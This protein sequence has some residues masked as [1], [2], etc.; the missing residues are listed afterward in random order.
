MTVRPFSPKLITSD[1]AITPKNEMLEQ[2]VFDDV[3][4]SA[5]GNIKIKSTMDN[6]QKIIDGYGITLSKNVI[7]KRL[8]LDVPW[9]DS[10]DLNTAQCAIVS[11]CNLNLY[12]KG[13]VGMFTQAL[14]DNNQYN[15]VLEWI[16]SVEWD[17]VDRFTELLSHVSVKAGFEAVRDIYFKRWCFSAVGML[18]NDGRLSNE[19]VL[20][21][22]GEQGLGKSAWVRKLI[23]PMY[24]YFQDGYTLEPNN[25]D[26]V[27]TAVSNWILELGE[28]D[29]TF[30]KSEIAA[31]KAFIT[32][33]KDTYRA[34]YDRF[35]VSHPRTTVL[36][37]SVNDDK[38]LK[39]ST[40][41]R[42]FWCLPVQNL[43]F[44]DEYNAQQLWAQVSHMQ[45]TEPVVDRTHNWF[46][47]DEEIVMRN[48]MNGNFR[49]DDPVEEM[50][51]EAYLGGRG[52][53]WTSA[54]EVCKVL[55]L[56]PTR[57]NTRAVS[58]VLK[59]FATTT[60]RTSK[61]TVFAIPAPKTE[62]STY[63]IR[64]NLQKVE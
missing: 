7:T 62:D 43:S 52:L 45:K 5:T 53:F 34:P 51:Y 58:L 31:L 32:S 21:F 61:Y 6:F 48:S 42:R 39:D 24:N 49:E 17:G 10:S 29:G 15:P 8:E 9:V 37:A 60:K 36:F 57:A 12:P 40:G 3:I 30:K 22:Q 33:V 18:K 64:N 19:G 4:L 11:Q 20:V 26:N 41:D 1:G 28:L 27:M 25:K 16:D 13:E 55:N 59:E 35:D 23:G 47:T 56:H 44:P 54:T 50:I 14:A 46:L 2:S 63:I 38:F